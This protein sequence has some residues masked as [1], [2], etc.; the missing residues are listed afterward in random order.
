MSCLQNKQIL[1]GV[2]G[3]IAAYKAPELVRRLRDKGA[4]VRVVMTT[5]AEG[6]ITT[7]SLQAV[8]GHPVHVAK[9]NADSES[10]MGHIDLARWADLVLI[11]PATA[12]TMARLANGFGDELLTTLCLAT[13]AP[14]AVAPAM[15]QQMWSNAATQ[16]NLEKIKSIGIEVFGP[17]VGDQACGETG[18]GRMLEPDDL[19]TCCEQLFKSIQQDGPLLELECLVTAGP[20]IEHLDPVRAITNFSSGRMGYAIAEAAA[21]AGATVTLVS[22]P[23]ALDV[24]HGVNRISV[25]SAEEM[26]KAVLSKIVDAD[27]FIGVAAVA[28]YRPKSQVTKK[29]K[30]NENNITIDLVKN[31]DILSEVAALKDRPFVV[32]FAAETENLEKNA[33]GKL[34]KKKLDMIAANKVGGKTSGFG[35]KPNELFV[36]CA[37]GDKH[38]LPMTDKKQLARQLVDLIGSNL[39][40]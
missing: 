34:K 20:T 36:F 2:S 13:S 32:G 40:G 17:G 10:G 1:L 9:M 16:V 19:V 4:D 18:P 37:N 23:V 12:N 39:S 26:R 35:D 15:N 3:G 30:K 21:A 28:D 6:F 25:K 24:P 14:I 38:K 27:I 33:L 7:L 5:A 31:P 8:S 11:A 29:I 22:G